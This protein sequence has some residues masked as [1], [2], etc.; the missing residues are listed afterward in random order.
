[1]DEASSLAMLK[2]KKAKMV[3]DLEER[4]EVF[5]LEI[6]SSKAAIRKISSRIQEVCPHTNVKSMDEFDYHRREN[7]TDY[8][9]ADCG[10]FLRRV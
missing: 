1:M 9:C 8:H 4:I 3:A 10:K 7:Y 2:K 5:G 6:A